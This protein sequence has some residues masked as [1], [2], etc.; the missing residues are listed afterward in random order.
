MVC[1]VVYALDDGQHYYV[2]ER[3][4]ATCAGLEAGGG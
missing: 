2:R 1:V 3:A 4:H